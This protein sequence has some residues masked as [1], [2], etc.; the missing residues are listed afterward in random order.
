MLRLVRSAPTVLVTLSF[1]L[2]AAA[3]SGSETA[4]AAYTPEQQKAAV[5]A[6]KA[7]TTSLDALDARLAA[8]YSGGSGFKAKLGKGEKSV[9]GLFRRFERPEE[10][11]R[12][13]GEAIIR[14]TAALH[15][16]TQ[17]CAVAR[18]DAQALEGLSRETAALLLKR[19]M[20]SAEN[21]TAWQAPPAGGKSST[22]GEQVL[23]CES[24]R[25]TFDAS[26]A[27]LREASARV[28]EAA[29]QAPQGVR[30]PRA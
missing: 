22:Q 12:E 16:A 5:D 13:E 21:I 7:G 18:G 14:R 20:T 19:G 17:A 3:A 15:A 23:D 1:G 30:V 2:A 24:A 6:L 9:K 4:Q 10:R 29:Q 27:S 28:H 8:A 11:A 25:K 26:A